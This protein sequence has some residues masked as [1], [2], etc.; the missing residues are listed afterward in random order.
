MLLHPNGLVSVFQ[1][2]S[3][4]PEFFVVLIV[5]L[6]WC[7][8]SE[9]SRYAD[10]LKDKWDNLNNCLPGQ[11]DGCLGSWERLEQTYLT[12]NKSYI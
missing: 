7:S 8:K 10:I 4:S 3:D 12:K 6:P 1:I 11:A 5:K 2:S 9:K